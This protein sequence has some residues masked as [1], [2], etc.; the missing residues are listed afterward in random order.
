[1]FSAARQCRLDTRFDAFYT[2]LEMKFN[3]ISLSDDHEYYFLHEQDRR[4]RI[5]FE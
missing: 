1:M 2:Q 3:T 4:S 5:F